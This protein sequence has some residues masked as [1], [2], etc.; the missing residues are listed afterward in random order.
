MGA[1]C[2]VRFSGAAYKAGKKTRPPCADGYRYHFWLVLLCCCLSL[3][4]QLLSSPPFLQQFICPFFFTI[5]SMRFC[6]SHSTTPMIRFTIAFVAVTSTSTVIFPQP[7]QLKICLGVFAWASMRSLWLS[8]DG[9]PQVC[10][11]GYSGFRGWGSWAKW[12][13]SLR[14]CFQTG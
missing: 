5:M 12:P 8:A 6:C 2:W 7:F 4:L 14:L 11:S 10:A 1:G 9:V 13:G 3:G